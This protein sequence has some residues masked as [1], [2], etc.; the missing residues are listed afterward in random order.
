M[1]T[2][3]VSDCRK[4]RWRSLATRCWIILPFLNALQTLVYAVF[5]ILAQREI[6]SKNKAPVVPRRSQ[7]NHLTV[8]VAFAVGSFC[9]PDAEELTAGITTY[10]SC[11]YFLVLT[12]KY[13][14]KQVFMTCALAY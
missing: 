3:R 8:F 7:A 2:V 12:D 1:M 6:L 9:F 11:R 10:S 13:G 14:R 5:T 4:T